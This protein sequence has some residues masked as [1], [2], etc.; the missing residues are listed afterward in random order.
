[1][2]KSM[3][4]DENSGLVYSE[5]EARGT[6]GSSNWIIDFKTPRLAKSKL[7]PNYE[8]GARPLLAMMLN[9]V[10]KLP[11]E[12]SVEALRALPWAFG[13]IIWQR[14]CEKYVMCFICLE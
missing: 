4:Y 13:E 5:F 12:L 2:M 9:K 7:E 6:K 11:Q 3:T 14:I 8:P 1:M 10:A